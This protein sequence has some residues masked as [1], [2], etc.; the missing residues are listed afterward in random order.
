MY[1]VKQIVKKLALASIVLGVAAA[2]PMNDAYA[3]GMG[4]G[5]GMGGGDPNARRGFF[6]RGLCSAPFSV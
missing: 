6:G 1:L 2:L 4:A 5:M 3:Q